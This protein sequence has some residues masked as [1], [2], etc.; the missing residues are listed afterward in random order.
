MVKFERRS[1][2]TI[3]E[4][5]PDEDS[6]EYEDTQNECNSTNSTNNNEGQA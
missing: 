5:K 4:K 1:V 6:E 3:G 2:M